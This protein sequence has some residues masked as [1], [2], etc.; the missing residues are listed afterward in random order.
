MTQ[1]TTHARLRLVFVDGK[2]V[3]PRR[4]AQST[5]GRVSS[6]RTSPRDSRSME[7]DKDSAQGREPYA[8]FRKC[9]AV[10]EQRAA[11]ASRSATVLDFKKVFRSILDYHHTVNIN[12][13]PSGEFTKRCLQDDNPNMDVLGMRRIRRE[14]LKA[15]IELRFNGVAR[16]FALR[17]GKSE[18]YVNDLLNDDGKKP[19]GEKVVADIEDAALLQTG[20]MSIP[21][22]PLLT[23]EAKLNRLERDFRRVIGELNHDEMQDAFDQVLEIK[24]RR[25][26]RKKA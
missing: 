16:R 5:S 15:L 1:E 20:Q 22:S 13:T 6:H 8:T 9:P 21:N 11:K 2:A 14:N 19:F 24:R 17:A 23:D 4:Y 26:K 10:V 3:E 18:S 7:I 25:K 12:A